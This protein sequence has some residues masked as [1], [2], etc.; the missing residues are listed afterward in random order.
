VTVIVVSFFESV[1]RDHS[2]DHAVTVA[3]ITATR[4]PPNPYTTL[5]DTT[6]GASCSKRPGSLQAV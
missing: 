5:M 3:Y 4:S 1:V 6:L 2:K